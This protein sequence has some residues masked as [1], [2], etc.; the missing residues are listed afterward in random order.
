MVP[1]ITLTNPGTQTSYDGDAINLSLTSRNSA[2]NAMSYSETNLPP[3]LSVGAG[4]YS[5]GTGH[6]IISGTISSNADQ[7]EPYSVTITATDTTTLTQGGQSFTWKVIQPTLT[8]TQP[9]DQINCDTDTVSLKIAA[10]ENASHT[11]TYSASGLPTGLSINTS[12]GI[13]S[14]TVGSNDSLQGYSVT[15]TATDSAAG[16]TASKTFNWTLVAIEAVLSNPGDQSNFDG[17][18]V[19]LTIAAKTTYASAG[20]FT[21]SVSGLPPGLSFN[22]GTTVISGT[23]ASN[24]D[25]NSPYGVTAS[26]T[27]TSAEL[28]SS[29]DFGWT[30]TNPVNLANPLD[31]DNLDGDT[32]IVPIY[33]TDSAGHSLSYSATGL[34]TG[35]S[36]NS[37]TGVM[38]GMV[39]STD[40]AGS[41]YSVVVTATDSVG[42]KASTSFNWEIDPLVTVL[43]PGDQ[44]N[45]EGDPVSLVVQAFDSAGNTLT[46]SASNLPSGLSID[47]STGLISGT[48]TGAGESAPYSVT[49][50]ATDGSIAVSQSFSWSIGPINIV[51]PGDQSNLDG[52]AVSLALRGAASNPGTDTFA[53]SV[54]VLP[55]G[56]TFN[57][58]TGVV[59]GTISD[60][61]ETSSPYSVTVTYIDETAQTSASQTFAWYVQA[62]AA[63]NAT[64]VTSAGA[65]I[66]EIDPT[67]DSNSPD[68]PSMA[69]TIVSGP[70]SGTLTPNAD[71]TYTYTPIS[72]FIGTDSFTFKEA[73]GG[74]AISNTSTETITVADSATDA[75]NTIS[76]RD[77]DTLT[78]MNSIVDQIN[79]AVSGLATQF[80]TGVS[81]GNWAGYNTVLTGTLR[82]LVDQLEYNAVENINANA[83]N[84]GQQT[85]GELFRIE[86]IKSDL[87]AARVLLGKVRDQLQEQV[88][89]FP[90]TNPPSP[91]AIL[92]GMIT[93]LR[94]ARATLA[95]TSAGLP[96]GNA[97]TDGIADLNQQYQALLGFQQTITTNTTQAIDN[98]VPMVT[99]IWNMLV[100]NN[101]AGAANDYDNRLLDVLSNVNNMDAAAGDGT[102]NLNDAYN[103]GTS[104]WGQVSGLGDAF[105]QKGVQRVLNK[106]GL[107]LFV[108]KG[109]LNYEQ[110]NGLVAVGDEYG[111]YPEDWLEGIDS[112][113]SYL[114]DSMTALQSVTNG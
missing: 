95:T 111:N 105:A 80:A 10:S 67:Q 1:S 99:D 92:Q 70:G 8:L 104:A 48:V 13:I 96:V 16:L 37:S 23:I 7:G 33:A 112:M 49:V 72:G 102:E 109:N 64:V 103:V 26:V 74:L 77:D 89:Q 38:A 5:A 25:Q 20:I 68:D 17:D 39:S 36:I 35:V 86:G 42:A 57:T 53:Y 108:V 6:A 31:Q 91:V 106:M 63:F 18:P 50:A 51:N 55:D 87:S 97:G 113:A 58:A 19:S 11:L 56:L 54:N 98:F 34:P 29:Q 22:S 81:S 114:S 69:T 79:T 75:L 93:N 21:F 101:F 52:D 9:K 45:C 14:G 43:N 4:S 94:T 66:T 71:G 24:A 61:A 3:G 44:T 47:T 41:P 76:G 59:S 110:Y 90:T 32:V 73:V 28:S 85:Q 12:T 27:D 60:G 100:N 83:T 78:G 107:A 15:V 40:D 84:A 30:V 65:P 62:P 2:S 46:Y 88:D 82:P